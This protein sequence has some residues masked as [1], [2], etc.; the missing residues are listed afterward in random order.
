M[1][2]FGKVVDRDV[3]GWRSVRGLSRGAVIKEIRDT[4]L[5]GDGVV[6]E[7]VTKD[8]APLA[9]DIQTTST[10]GVSGISLFYGEGRDYGGHERQG[11]NMSVFDIYAREQR[12][13]AQRLPRDSDERQEALRKSLIYQAM[14]SYSESELYE[15]MDAGV[16]NRAMRGYFLAALERA[17]LTEDERDLVMRCLDGVLDEY[18]AQQ[19]ANIYAVRTFD[20]E[21]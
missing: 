17:K 14:G 2:Y 12:E 7:A 9:L 15:I 3:I 4:S 11:D 8:G 5:D 13:L 19:A 18:D 16:Y 10:G 21:D 6:I 20:K 1:K